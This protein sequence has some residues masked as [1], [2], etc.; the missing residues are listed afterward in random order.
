MVPF[1]NFSFILLV[2][3]IL[4]FFEQIQRFFPSDETICSFKNM[5]ETVVYV[6]RENFDQSHLLNVFFYLGIKCN[7]IN[8][9][10]VFQNQIVLKSQLYRLLNILKK[11]KLYCEKINASFHR[12]VFFLHCAFIK[13]LYQWYTLSVYLAF[14]YFLLLQSQ[15]R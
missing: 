11:S 10:I 7:V 5:Y 14:I 4:M 13:A 2:Q 1:I 6:I 8:C 9:M 12:Q 15:R 3:R